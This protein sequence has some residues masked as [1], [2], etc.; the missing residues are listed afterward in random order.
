[1]EV[2]VYSRFHTYNTIKRLF[3]KISVQNTYYQCDGVRGWVCDGMRGWVCDGVRGWVCD[4]VRGCVCDGVRGG[5]VME[6]GDGCVMEWGDGRVM[7]W[8]GG[9]VMEW[10]DGRVMEWGG[11]CVMEW[12]MG[13]W[14]S[15]GMGMWWSEGMGVWWSEAIGVTHGKI[16][17]TILRWQ[18]AKIWSELP[19]FWQQ[20][21]QTELKCCQTRFLQWSGNKATTGE[22]KEIATS[23]ASLADWGYTMKLTFI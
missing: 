21:Q 6:W 5:C 20:R 9:C 12:G 23:Q 22:C 2:T 4:G 14:W 16:A 7:E 10:G 8:G 1:M 3:N 11:G 19:L 18:H 17:F 13:V 15:E